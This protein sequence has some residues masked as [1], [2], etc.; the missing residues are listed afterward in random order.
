MK[1]NFKWFVAV[2]VI[3]IGAIVVYNLPYFKE[4]RLYDEIVKERVAY[5][6]EEYYSKYPSGRYY[7]DVMMLEVELTSAP[8]DIIVRYLKEF[9]EGKY[10]DKMREMYDGLWALE[11]DKYENRDKTGES[12]EAVKFMT[13]MLH[14]MKDNMV[15]T[16]Y[17]KLNPTIS[18]KDYTDYDENV[19]GLLELLYSDETLQL[20][21]EN[22]IPLNENFPKE[23][24]DELMEILSNGVEKSFSRMFSPELVSVVTN[25]FE[26]D[27]KSPVITFNYT[28]KNRNEDADNRIPEIWVYS[29]NNIPKSYILAIDVSFDAEFKIPNSSVTYIYSEVGDPGNEISGI[30]DIEDGYRRMTVACFAKFSDKM[31]AN[32]GLEKVYAENDSVVAE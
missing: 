28:I 12:P 19:R 32:L 22:I 24:K 11:F 20:K 4:K 25:S 26:A 27:E 6:C 15:N 3:A 7:E 14:Y 10:V 16:V 30:E 8:F 5:K 29:T 31:S 2:V 23:T 18:L 1:K 9:P 17:L 21:T 13:S